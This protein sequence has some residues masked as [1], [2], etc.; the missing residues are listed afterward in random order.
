MTNKQSAEHIAL[1][2]LRNMAFLKLRKNI[3]F[4]NVLRISKNV[5]TVNPVLN[6]V[7]QDVELC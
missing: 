6:R 4:Q 1:R 5:S 2:L 7:A 3:A